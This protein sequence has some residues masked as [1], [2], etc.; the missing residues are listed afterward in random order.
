[1]SVAEGRRQLALTVLNGMYGDI[2][3]E[4]K[5]YNF[6]MPDFVKFDDA[7]LAAVLNYVV[8]DLAH[9]SPTLAPFS[10]A[11]IAAA[12]TPALSSDAVHQQ[13]AALISLLGL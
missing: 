1:M 2:A 13:R 8:F 5:H 7:M 11:E 12:R 3:V 6:K 10:P 9:G 4:Q